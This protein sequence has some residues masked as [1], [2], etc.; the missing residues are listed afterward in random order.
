MSVGWNVA[1]LLNDFILLVALFFVH[2]VALQLN[3]DLALARIAAG[4]PAGETEGEQDTSVHTIMLVT[5]VGLASFL[6]PWATLV[7]VLCCPS[8]PPSHLVRASNPLG[9]NPAT[10]LFLT[11]AD[12]ISLGRTSMDVV[13]VGKTTVH[14]C[15][16]VCM[17]ALLDSHLVVALNCKRPQRLQV[18]P[19]LS[20]LVRELEGMATYRLPQKNLETLKA[21]CVQIQS[22]AFWGGGRKK[23]WYFVP[24]ICML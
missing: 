19:E 16:C 3:C 24:L 17:R 12:Y 10:Q 21:W 1:E 5:Q 20:S 15:A 23:W 11:L 4:K 7:T 22:G 13:R 8:H 6:S 14:V 2:A 9:L 18:R